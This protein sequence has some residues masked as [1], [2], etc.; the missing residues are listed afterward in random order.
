MGALSEIASLSKPAVVVPIP[1]SHQVEN[2]RAFSSAKAALYVAQDQPDFGDILFQQ[3]TDLLA[4][5]DRRAALGNAAHAFLPTDDG[6][7]LAERMVAC[8]KKKPV[9][10]PVG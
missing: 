6:M 8:V 3:T 4:D 7:A 10:P 2:I 5:N 9:L 1:K